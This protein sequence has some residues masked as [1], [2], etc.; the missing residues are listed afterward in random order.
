MVLKLCFLNM[1]LKIYE[2]DPDQF[3]TAPELAWQATLKI[4]K[5]KLDLLTDI[6]RLLMVDKGIRGEI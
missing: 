1:C 3:L 6:D 2:L 4:I 5:V